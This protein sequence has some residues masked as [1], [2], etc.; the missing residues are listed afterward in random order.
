[1]LLRMVAGG[2][3]QESMRRSQGPF[4]LIIRSR[5][6]RLRRVRQLPVILLHR[7]A[8][9][10]LKRIHINNREVSRVLLDTNLLDH[11]E[12]SINLA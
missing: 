1:M 6:E 12:Y 9:R 10:R 8:F 2:H 5:S 11:S 7:D 3:S 4:H